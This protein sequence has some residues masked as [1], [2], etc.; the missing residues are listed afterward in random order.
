MT[1]VN[2]MT[3]RRRGDR[4]V[5]VTSAAV[6]V[7]HP[8]RW[9]RD[10]HG[11]ASQVPLGRHRR[12]RDPRQPAQERRRGP[13]GHRSGDEALAGAHG[14]VA[15]RAHAAQAQPD[16][17]LRLPGVRMARPR[18]R[19]T[20]TPPSSARTARRPSPR[21]PPPTTASRRS[22]PSTASRSSRSTPTTGSATRVG[23]CTRWCAGATRTHYEPIS[24]D[25][26]LRHDRATRC[27]GWSTPTRRSSTP[28]ARPPTR[29]RTPTSCSPAPSAPTT[30]PTAPT[31]ATSRPRSRW[32]R[33]SGS[34]RRRSTS[35]TCTTPT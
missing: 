10:R 25:D 9:V 2:D 1:I 34:A 32:P 21:R 16:R 33:R 7:P 8:G 5:A 11:A 4:F 29:R 14:S 23:W 35:R 18:L 31:C 26:G 3:L 20:G 12:E 27:A 22:S 28:P 15:H 6:R 24:W 13:A 30:S 17:R 19:T